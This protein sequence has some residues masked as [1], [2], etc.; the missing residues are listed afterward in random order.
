MFPALSERM[1]EEP[2]SA[3]HKNQSHSYYVACA[4]Y[5]LPCKY[6]ILNRLFGKW[7]VEFV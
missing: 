1:D 4:L 7:A 2:E 6:K 3:L 5:G